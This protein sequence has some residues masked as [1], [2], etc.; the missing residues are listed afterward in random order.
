MN[1]FYFLNKRWVFFS[2]L[3]LLV[4]GN[5]R[6]NPGDR[7]QRPTTTAN[8]LGYF[9]S[10]ALSRSDC[11][12]DP[13][14]TCIIAKFI[15]GFPSLPFFDTWLSSAGRNLEQRTYSYCKQEETVKNLIKWGKFFLKKNT[16]NVREVLFQPT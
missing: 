12:Q 13:E 8:Y 16:A 14:S 15:L 6:A 4:P 10:F 9:V 3:I 7:N 5:K 1:V 11:K 2:V